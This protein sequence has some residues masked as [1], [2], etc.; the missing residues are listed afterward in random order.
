[1]NYKLCLYENLAHMRMTELNMSFLNMYWVICC[2]FTL[3]SQ[4]E[5]CL[6]N[7]IIYTTLTKQL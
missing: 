3:S 2:S 1:M 5:N 4:M 6:P 7:L